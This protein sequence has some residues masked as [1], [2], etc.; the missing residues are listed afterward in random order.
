MLFYHL[1]AQCALHIYLHH[2]C[3]HKGVIRLFLLPVLLV[4]WEIGVSTAFAIFHPLHTVS[5]THTRYRCV[6]QLFSR[7]WTK[8]ASS[9]LWK[10]WWSWFS[11]ESGV[12]AHFWYIHLPP[13]HHKRPVLR[14]CNCAA[15]ATMQLI[16]VGGNCMHCILI[17]AHFYIAQCTP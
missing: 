13:H 12:S 17:I 3:A 5:P 10:F 9:S 2:L 8:P 15:V 16:E 1:C 4:T 14:I 11:S 7:V 6:C